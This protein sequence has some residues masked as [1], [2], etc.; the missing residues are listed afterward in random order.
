MKKD[1]TQSIKIIILGLLLSVG[2][3]FAANWS[4][5]IAP[6]PS[7][8]KAAPINVSNSHQGIGKLFNGS[9]LHIEGTLA[10]QASQPS[11][12]LVVFGNATVANDLKVTNF[13]GAGTRTVCADTTGTL[14]VCP[15]TCG[16]ANGGTFSSLTAN[17]PNLCS[18]GSASN[19]TSTASGWTWKCGT[20]NCSATKTSI[21]NKTRTY[22]INSAGQQVASGDPCQGCNDTTF[23]KSPNMTNVIAQ[24]WGA[25]GGGGGGIS[26]RTI[27]L[28]TH[29][30]NPSGGGGGG[31]G[32]ST[33]VLST[34]GSYSITVGHGGMGGSSFGAGS[35]YPYLIYYS[36]PGQNGGSSTITIGNT[37]V[38]SAGGGHGGGRAQALGSWV[39]VQGNTPYFPPS[40]TL[41]GSGGAGGSGQING[42]PGG[43]GVPVYTYDQSG[44]ITSYSSASH[45]AYYLWD[46]TMDYCDQGTAGGL[47]GNGAN[48]GPK[49]GKG[50]GGYS[51]D[52]GSKEIT[53]IDG[54]MKKSL[55]ANIILAGATC[56]IDQTPSPDVCSNVQ[57]CT[58]NDNYT[59]TNLNECCVDS[60][61]GISA[62]I[63]N[64][65]T[66]K[67]EFPS[68]YPPT[69]KYPQCG[70]VKPA[71]KGED[72]RVIITWQE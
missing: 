16:S 24:V 38:L 15:V 44:N 34:N 36:D 7:G 23:V 49:G 30:N 71:E 43:N 65:S 52:I 25:G 50:G 18:S 21:V 48:N 33:G 54:R 35:N 55:A 62:S 2:I 28:V 68:T 4:S 1:I 9:L 31:G 10:S 53:Q 58:P 72:G 47:G 19:F 5:P 26:D 27:V 13:A 42:S 3:S 41:S 40:G 67:C 37:P 45:Q 60:Q 8:N 61:T 46:Q 12:A 14:I 64:P 6:Y 17:D 69:K 22:T 59:P 32:Y 39:G 29:L 20:A 63:Y 56:S 66:G 51:G 11:P 57:N 70:T